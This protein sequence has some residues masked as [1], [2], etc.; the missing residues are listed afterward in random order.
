MFCF[1]LLCVDFDLNDRFC[2]AKDLE[3]SWENTKIPEPLL[4]FFGSLFNFQQEKFY[5]DS[6]Q[7]QTDNEDEKPHANSNV[8]DEKRR[9]INSLFQIMFYMLHNGCKKTPLHIMN[10]EAIY[11]ACK[12][13]TLIT[14]FN[15]FGLCTSYDELMRFQN[16]MASYTIE[17]C[18]DAVPFPSHFNRSMFTM[19]AFDNFDHEE[20]TLSGIG[21]SHDTVTVLFQDDGG[22]QERKPRISA[23]NVKHGPRV[24]DTELQCQKLRTFHKPSHKTNIPQNY[25]VSASL[26]DQ[27]DLLKEY[28]KLDIAWI[29]GRVDLSEIGSE[30]AFVKPK[31]Q[32][33]PIWSAAN[34]IL[35]V[36]KVPLKRIGFLP[37]L[38]YPVTQYDT[39][40]SSLK[41]LKGIL[42]YLDQP[43]LSV[44]CDEGVYHIAR[45]IQLI[46]P[47]EFSNIVLCLGSFHMAKIALGCIGKYLKGSGA[48]NILIESGTFGVNVVVSVLNGRHYTRSLKGLQLLK[49]AL[50]RLQWAEFFKKESNVLTHRKLLDKIENMKN[51]ISKK[52]KKESIDDLQ[53]F[54]ADCSVL[55]ENFDAFIAENCDGNETFR[56]WNSFIN[57]MSKLE[58][59]VRSDRQGDWNLQLQS[60]KDLL[61]LFAAFDS[62]NYLRWCSLYL[63]DMYRL[64]E[65]SPT[66][67]NAFMEG[68]FSIKRTP[69]CF[70]AVGADM[71]LEQTINKS[72]KCSSGIIGNS[73]K[74]CY[75]AK[76]EI[77]YHEMLAITN[78]HR[79]VSSSVQSSY[80]QD[81]NRSFN[82]ACTQ[83]DETD[84]QA[85][86]DV[87]QKKENPFSVKTLCSRLHNIIT[88]EIVPEDISQQILNAETI[89]K[90][91][92]ERFREK[93]FLEKT[94]RICDTVHRNNLK[95]FASMHQL[96]SSKNITQRKT[97]KSYETAIQ[98]TLDVAKERGQ[99][100]EQLLKYDISSTSYLFDKE[101]FM[102]SATKSDLTKELEKRLSTVNYKEPNADTMMTACLV[103][104]MANVR[105][106][107]TKTRETKTFGEFVHNFLNF[108]KNSA[109]GASRVDLVFDSYLDKTIKDSER[110]R[111][112]RTSAVELN[113]V[114][115]ET[116]LPVQIEKFWPSS[117]NKANLETLIHQD[118]MLYPWNGNIEVLVSAFDLMHGKSLQ[119]FKLLNKLVVRTPDLDVNIEEADLRLVLHAFHATRQGFKRV[120]ILSQDTDVL[121]LFLYNWKSLASFG[122]KEIWIAAGVGDT[123]RY[124]PIHTLADKLGETLCQVLPAVHALT[125]CDYTSKFG[126]KVASLK[127]TPEF[128]LKDFGTLESNIE[129]QITQ[130]EQYL[131]KVKKKGSCC[132]TFDQLRS[133]LYHHSKSLDLPP[134]SHE[135]RLHI[136]RAL[137]ATHIMKTGITTANDINDPR[138]YGYEVEDELLIPQRGRNPI[139]EE[140]TVSC[141]CS[142]CSTDRCQCRAKHLPCCLFCKC[143]SNFN[144]DKCA[145]LFA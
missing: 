83:S 113:K 112:A 95:T 5:V 82:A 20:A 4:R 10:S 15:H 125:G 127:A 69:G 30:T 37:V 52:A 145:N 128:F 55:I 106:I 96:P 6:K 105:K 21:G 134:T 8:S 94:Q 139:P 19:A 135:T 60:I 119:S 120:I 91:V 17:S 48:E 38:P 64:P 93:R 84:I 18:D 35:C 61:P 45:E 133:Y 136:L 36:D 62:T 33:M 73:R 68:K 16:D 9:K 12:S 115:R 42:K 26:I 31:K 121:I 72:Q 103:D 80:D 78:L 85:I 142:K 138:L 141:N 39:V 100:M 58:N 111:R 90:T 118:A 41:N 132:K 76:W 74:K 89:G 71:A 1:A 75:V 124:I 102:T 122:L 107:K 54:K 51:N 7:D 47:D 23:T 88:N 59:L 98:R 97:S 53:E 116:P 123:S 130:A 144:N 77:L 140:F 129:N 43:S 24:F 92:Y 32:Y 11:D 108:V 70:K 117:K 14:S 57:M 49:E 110:K 29:L 3:D 63:E 2:D 67:H 86:I 131:I 126:T 143:H 79:K 81:I 87:I 40:Y 104:V 101:G 109:H 34:A 99:T 65:T 22:Q 56:F 50:I 28:R 114:E 13:A 66:T 137:Y 44:T 25:L 46:R 27:H